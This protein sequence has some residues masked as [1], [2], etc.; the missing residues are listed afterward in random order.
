MVLIEWY[1]IELHNFC[2]VLT[3][4]IF[5]MHRVLCSHIRAES[6]AQRIT[7]DLYL[8]YFLPL[9]LTLYSAI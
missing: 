2:V 6:A 1:E 4:R 8:S 5:V 7:D 3:Q 9:S